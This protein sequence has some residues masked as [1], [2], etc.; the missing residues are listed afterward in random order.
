MLET[1][2][3]VLEIVLEDASFA[4]DAFFEGVDEEFTTGEVGNSG[5]V[6]FPGDDGTGAL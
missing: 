4:F 1:C 5:A 3:P 6:V 2:A